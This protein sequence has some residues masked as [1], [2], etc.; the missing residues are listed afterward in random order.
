M[1]VLSE[2]R[3]LGFLGPGP[4]DIHLVHADGFARAVTAA[5]TRVLDLGSG[6]GIPGLALANTWPHSAISLLESSTRRAEF[7]RR[8]V[9][10]LDLGAR[11]SV[12]NGRAELLGCDEGF[13]GGFDVVLARSFGPP[14]VVAECGAPFLEQGGILLVSEPPEDGPLRWPGPGLDELGLRDEGVATADPRVRRLRQVRPCPQRF[15]RR[16]GVPAKRP[17]W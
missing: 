5:P 12:L 13:R 4:I 1:E 7:L 10:R 2:A 17:L 8:W 6:G 15:P 9:Q 11:V 3:D 16:T 14:A